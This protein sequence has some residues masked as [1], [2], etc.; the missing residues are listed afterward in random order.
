M[1]SVPENVTYT[2]DSITGGN[3]GLGRVTRIQSQSVTIDRVYDAR[4]NITSE[5]RTIGGQAHT[6]AY[7][8]DAADRVASLTYPSGRIV[9]YARDGMGRISGVTTKKT[10]ASS[11]ETLASSIAYMPVSRLVKS[12]DYGNGLNDWHTYT[13]DYETDV[14]GTYDG[15]TSL[16]ASGTPC[17]HASGAPSLPASGALYLHAS[18]TPC[19]HVSDMTRSDVRPLAVYRPVSSTRC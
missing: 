6:V 18:G 1:D 17:L 4:G 14:L 8:W 7:T 11:T 19:L 12:F 10:S 16:P 5:T 9:T 3:K 2:Y 13:L 15:A